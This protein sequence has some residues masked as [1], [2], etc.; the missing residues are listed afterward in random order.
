MFHLCGMRIFKI[1]AFLL[2]LAVVFG[3]FGAH[4]L[5]VRLTPES[6]AV[7]KTAVEYHFYHALGLMAVAIA[8]RMNFFN[9]KSFKWIS[10]LML[11]GLGFFS[12]SLYLLSTRDIHGLPVGFLGPITPIG[13][14]LFIA[15]WIMAALKANVHSVGK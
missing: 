13:G 8:F 10:G 1:A 15:A 6:L 11:G 3:A 7:W 14:V 2:A 9:E 5:K 4:A 12:G